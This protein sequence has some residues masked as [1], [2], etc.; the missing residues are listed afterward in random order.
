MP[1]CIKWKI[2]PVLLIVSLAGVGCED[3]VNELID[4]LFEDKS[5]AEEV[6]FPAEVNNQCPDWKRRQTIVV[7]ESMKLPA[8]CVFEQV[9]I[10]LTGPDIDFDCNNAVFNGMTKVKRNDYREEYAVEEAPQ[11]IAFFIND[12]ES[13]VI[14]SSNI[15]ISNCQIIN[16]IHAVEVQLDLMDATKQALRKGGGNEDE[17]RAKAPS[18][19]QVLNSKI[20]NS[21]GSGIYINHYVTGFRLLNSSLKGSGGPGLYLDAGSRAATV[22]NSVLEGNGYF[23]YNSQLRMREARRTEEAQRE[24]IAIDAS[25]RHVISNNTFRDNADGG[26]YLYKNC[27]EHAASDP[28]QLPRPEGADFNRVEGNT[29]INETKAVWL[30]ERADRDLSGFD[31]GDELIYED[32]KDDEKYYRDFATQNS[33]INNTFDKNDTGIR[34]MDDAN[35]VQGNTFTDTKDFDIDVG[36][37]VREEVNDPVSGTLIS[38]NILSK[39]DGIKFRN[40]S[41]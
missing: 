33:I 30:A 41:D 6:N 28:S 2:F 11:G 9:T 38:G 14:R 22:N 23:S 17:L 25:T 16:Y 34:I 1:D 40:G 32:T 39:M 36:S 29:F 4:D 20:I 18:G 12:A 5:Y 37:I 8:N 27:W 26:V 19:I 31:C 15:K 21:H 10:R 35:I 3:D 13:A 7:D 24:A